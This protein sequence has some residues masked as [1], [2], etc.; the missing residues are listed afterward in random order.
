MLG[1][2][3]H[4][5]VCEIA[6]CQNEF[7]NAYSPMTNEIEKVKLV[8]DSLRACLDAPTGKHDMPD[9]IVTDLLEAIRE[10]DVSEVGKAYVPLMSWVRCI[11]QG[12]PIDQKFK[13]LRRGRYLS[14]G[15]K[16]RIEGQGRRWEIYRYGELWLPQGTNENGER[17]GVP[18]SSLSEAMVVIEEMECK[19]YG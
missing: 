19:G 10:L 12:Q 1:D 7:R 6:R 14:D 9:Q 17:V 13:R 3:L 4:D 18:C 5:A 11:H 2:V 15:G 16:W 8:I